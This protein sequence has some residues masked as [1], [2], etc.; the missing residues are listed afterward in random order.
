VPYFLELEDK[1]GYLQARV[2]G[3]NSSEAVVGSLAVSRGANRRLFASAPDS[4]HWLRAEP[5][6][7][8]PAQ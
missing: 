8:G 6:Q 5:G 2:V 4:A 1:P 7:R 3:V